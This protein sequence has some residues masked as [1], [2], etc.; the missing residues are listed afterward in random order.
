MAWQNEIQDAVYTSPSGREFTF[1]YGS[2]KSDTDLKTSTFTFPETDGALVVSLGVGGRRFPLSCTFYGEDCLTKASAFEEGLKER[3]YGELQHPVYGIHKVVPTGTISRS[4][5][6]TDGLNV[7]T[8]D[9]TFSETIIDETFPESKIVTE[10]VINNALDNAFDNI[11]AEAAKDFVFDNVNDKIN[12]QIETRSVFNKVADY[13]SNIAKQSSEAYTQFQT[14]MASA[15]KAVNN[16]VQDTSSAVS[17]IMNLMRIPS[18]L[19]IRSIT[20]VEAYSNLIGDLISTY[21]KDPIG[22]NTVRNQAVLAIAAMEGAI[23][24]CSSGV[25]LSMN[26]SGVVNSATSSSKKTSGATFCNN[27]QETSN[28]ASFKSREDAIDTA[29]QLATLY[30]NIIDFIDAKTSEDLFVHTGEGM[31]AMHDI[32]IKGLQFIVYRSFDMDMRKEITL[33]RDRQIMELLAELYGDFDRIDE[34]IVDNNLTVDE[35]ALIPMG[36]KVAYYV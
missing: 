24:A 4:D 13:M 6:L 7:S 16:F 14:E 25:C 30:D 11:A 17:G 15:E 5:N 21:K 34:F 9:V 32:I 19:C 2:L 26:G 22:L 3:G 8:V 36:R 35:I 33:V 20:K 29:E 31:D 27:Q 28:D 12:A 23:T 10:D 18:K 1:H